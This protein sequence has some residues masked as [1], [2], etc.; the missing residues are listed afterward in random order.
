[1]QEDQQN[2]AA[3]A[4]KQAKAGPGNLQQEEAGCESDGELQHAQDLK[5]T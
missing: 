3:E 2:R 5:H 4:A 1:M